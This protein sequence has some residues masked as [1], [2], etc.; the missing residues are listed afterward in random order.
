MV[1]DKTKAAAVCAAPVVPPKPRK[2][3]KPKPDN[4]FLKLGKRVFKRWFPFQSVLPFTEWGKKLKLI[5]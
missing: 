5:L 2:V 4:C 3:Y 1:F